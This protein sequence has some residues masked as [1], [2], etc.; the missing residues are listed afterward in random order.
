MK[1]NKKVVIGIIVVLVLIGVITLSYAFLSVGGKQELGNTFQS[2]CLNIRIDSESNAISLNNAKPVTDVEGLSTE[3]YTFTVKN[4][5]ST[6]ADFIINIENIDRQE[7]SLNSDYL[8]VAINGEEFDN[9]VSILSSNITA[10]PSVSNAY[11]AYTIYT[12]SIEGNTTR[13]FKIR[14]WLDY[15][16]TKE[17]AASKVIKNKINVIAKSDVEVIN[18]PT[19]KQNL[20]LTKMLGNIT[21]TVGNAKYCVT[22]SSVCTPNKEVTIEN[23]KTSIELEIKDEKQVVCIS[24]DNGTVM[25]SEPRVSGYCPEGGTSCKSIMANIDTIDTRTDFSTTITEETNKKIYQAEDDDGVTYYY[26]GATQDNYVKFAGKYWRIIR[27]N[28][29]GT[30]RMIYDGDT[31]RANGSSLTVE[32][33]AFNSHNDDNMY[34]GFKY[35][36]GQVHGIGTESPIL[37][38]SNTWYEDNLASYSDKIDPNAGFCNDREPSTNDIESNGLGGA[39]TTQTY[40]GAYLRFYNGGSWGTTQTPT[41]KCKNSGD[42]FT[43]TTATKGN[44]SLTNPIGLVTADEV[45]Y[46][47]GLGE[48]ENSNYYLYSGQTYWTMSPRSFGLSHSYVFLVESDGSF[49]ARNVD[50][51]YGV[52]PVINLRADLELT[53]TGTMNDPYQVSDLDKAGK[54]IL[55][56]NE[57]KEEIPDFSK[58]TCSEGCDDNN[59][60][61]YKASDDDGISYYFRGSVENNYVKFANKFWRIIRI[62]GDGSIRMIYDGTSIHNNGASTS[63]SIAVASQT[64]NA[65]FDN[66]MYVGFKYTSG[67][68]HGTG[69]KSN[70]LTQLETWYNNNLASYASKLDTNAGFCGD[71][72]PSTSETA[73]NNS[74]GTGTTTTYYGAYIRVYMNRVPRLNCLIEDLYTL[75]GASKGNKTLANPIGLITADEVSMAGGVYNKANKSYYLYNGQVY[76]TLSPSN[77]LNARV[78]VVNSTGYLGWDRVDYTNGVRPV[79]NLKADTIFTGTGTMSDPYVVV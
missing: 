18:K 14:E 72:T 17:Q 16:A 5:C 13:T 4:T 8:K 58:T 3:G 15:D 47:G 33:Y 64:F 66:N 78:F 27:I 56:H 50:F 46:A 29:D 34:V 35:T 79:I 39:G 7:N 77:A 44:K 40:Y 20:K 26:A 1:R 2:G 71:R 53:G 22:E 59:S 25:C 21:G 61:L 10:T 54:T 28:G 67:Q 74:G 69:T 31:A 43:K 24:L 52:R 75:S 12:G 60:G 68:V 70:A 62:N 19:I 76:W 30:I 32:K 11:E 9:I 41:F 65:N 36:S 51:P 48:K 45:V 23:N 49:G 38:K 42:L 57:I 6:S 55:S 37:K 63:D 73:I